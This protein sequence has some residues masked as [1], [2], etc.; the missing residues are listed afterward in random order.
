[1]KEWGDKYEER[2]NERHHQLEI[3]EKN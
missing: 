2:A 1:M 3:S